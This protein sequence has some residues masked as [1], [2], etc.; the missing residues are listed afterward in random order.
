M[1]SFRDITGQPH[2]KQHLMR[3]ISRRQISHAY[4]LSG[5]E[6][7]GK[8]ALAR[9]FAQTLLC[10]T[11]KEQGYPEGASPCKI[12]SACKKIENDAHPDV[13]TL[14]HEKPLS[15]RVDEIEE[16]LT[17]DAYLTPY[18]A[19]YK[20]Y[21]VPDA[22]FMTTD[23]QNKLLKTLEEPP[24]YVC[25]LLLADSAQSLLPT[26][27]SRTIPLPL[28]PVPER[29]I[30]GILQQEDSNE[31]RTTLAARIAR[32][33]P[34]KAHYLAT[35]A[36][37]EDRN[38]SLFYLLEHLEQMA[39]Y[40]IADRLQLL[41]EE[42]ED[43]TSVR[44]ECMETIRLVL[45]DILVYKATDSKDYL[46]LQDEWEYIRDVAMHTSYAELLATE[47][48]LIEA[49]ERLNANVNAQLTLESFFLYARKS[50]HRTRAE[51]TRAVRF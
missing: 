1:P 12:C 38:R 5:E 15:I 19:D 18:A 14:R 42:A 51:D 39:L 9:A 36:R 8:E 28:R 4:L 50:L 20:L 6:K 3:A 41:L 49:R 32:G 13:R 31:Y 43:E 29:E 27:R 23:A 45:R 21:I 33:N 46:I 24:D 30:L 16:Q 25:I 11:L 35:D 34:G 7:M 37:F 47:R 17:N 40:E 48:K 10:E 2:I 22:Q 44:M 26:I